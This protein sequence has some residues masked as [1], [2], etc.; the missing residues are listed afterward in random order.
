MIQLINFLEK[1]KLKL[2]P[3]TPVEAK[4][5]LGSLCLYVAGE[6][7]C[8]EPDIASLQLGLNEILKIGLEYWPYPSLRD[9]PDWP[10]WDDVSMA[11]MVDLTNCRSERVHGR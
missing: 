10:G 3:N 7:R 1:N 5:E 2:F 6:W 4:Y 8:N 11:S 9:N